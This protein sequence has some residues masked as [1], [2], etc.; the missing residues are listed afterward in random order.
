[1]SRS[2]SRVWT[3]LIVTTSVFAASL[4]VAPLAV[5]QAQPPCD[6]KCLQGFIDKYLEALVA[7]DATRAPF[8]PGVKATENGQAL[9]VADGLWK[10]A[11]GNSKYRLYFAD[12]P[13]G[14]VG[15]IGVIKEHGLPAIMALRLKV[16]NQLITEAETIVAR[17][18]ANGGFAKPENFVKPIPI[19]ETVLPPAE[20]V[21]REEMI[22]AA[23]HYFTGLDEQDSGQNVPFDKDCQRREN[24][25]VSA[26]SPDPKATG[27]MK[28]GCKAQFDTGFSKIVTD[29]RERR[30][31]IVDEERG[32]IFS[33]IFF[34]HAGNVASYS[35]PDGKTVPV[36]ALFRRPLT[37]MI[38]ELFKIKRGKIR[39][40]E[41]VLLEVP[42][43]MP[44]GWGEQGE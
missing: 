37:F 10:T 24:G 32:L 36:N 20:R 11:D 2:K 14:Q 21:S 39:Q 27:M 5:A 25:T 35:T 17:A 28:M 30:F 33:I 18:Q 13:Q 15:F 3:G 7:R 12:V 43:G 8:A 31:P 41:A 44:S 22:R 42:Y 1:M 9:G 29:V 34:D 23:D 38:G 16:Q 6:R 40:I 26:N 4:C 19:L